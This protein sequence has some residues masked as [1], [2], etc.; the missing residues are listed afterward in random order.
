MGGPAQAGPGEI[1]PGASRVI[2][3]SWYQDFGL[4]SLDQ[5]IRSVVSL[6]FHRRTVEY[7]EVGYGLEPSLITSSQMRTTV[8]GE[9]LF[10]PV[11]SF[12]PFG[13]GVQNVEKSLMVLHGNP[14]DPAKNICSIKIKYLTSFIPECIILHQ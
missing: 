4:E 11:Q 9:G 6:Q 3:G 10:C 12:C 5:Q 8:M 1:R 14:K 13:H 2:A 7:F